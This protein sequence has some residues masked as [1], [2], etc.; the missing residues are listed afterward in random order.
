MNIFYSKRLISSAVGWLVMLNLVEYAIVHIANLFMTESFGLTLEYIRTYLGIIFESVLVPIMALIL[1][2]TFT[3]CGIKR[4]IGAAFILSLSRLAYCLFYYYMFYI[5]YGFDTAESIPLSLLTSALICLATAVEVLVYFGISLIALKLTRTDVNYPSFTD[6]LA[7]RM[8]ENG[9]LDT[10]NPVT[11]CIFSLCSLSFIK[12][13]VSEIT[14]TVEFFI[15]YGNN[16][17]TD[18]IL[19]IVF[20]YIFILLTFILCYLCLSLIK[21]KIIKDRLAESEE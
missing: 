6:R 12:N 19:L 8:S 7:D 20:N 17:S 9:F 14:D 15:E 5:S 2:I 16:F 11:V 13:L 18:E 1:L 10:S 4:A 21:K 3:Y